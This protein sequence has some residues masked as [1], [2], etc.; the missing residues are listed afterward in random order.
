M[1]R[2]YIDLDLEIFHDVLLLFPGWRSGDYRGAVYV[3]RRAI[4]VLVSLLDHAPMKKVQGLEIV[5]EAG[6]VRLIP[7]SQ[8][9]PY[10][11]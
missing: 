4:D 9:A 3:L 11:V 1:K 8:G 2:A 6:H 7:L 5:G 10:D